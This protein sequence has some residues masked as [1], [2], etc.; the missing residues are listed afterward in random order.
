MPQP[1]DFIPR[2]SHTSQSAFFSRPMHQDFVS[3]STSILRYVG[4]IQYAFRLFVVLK[5]E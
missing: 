3:V 1:L 4:N 2:N 5:P